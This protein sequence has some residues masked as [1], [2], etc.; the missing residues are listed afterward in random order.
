MVVK[1]PYL[2]NSGYTNN[3]HHAH[4]S[5]GEGPG[6]QRPSSDFAK[7]LSASLNYRQN[8]RLKQGAVPTIVDTSCVDKKTG[9]VIRL[10][11][12]REVNVVTQTDGD[13]RKTRR[14]SLNK[15]G[16]ISQQQQQQ[17]EQQ[18]HQWRNFFGPEQHRPT[19]PSTLEGTSEWLSEVVSEMSFPN[20]LKFSQTVQNL[21]NPHSQRTRSMNS[22][23]TPQQQQQQRQGLLSLQAPKRVF[24]SRLRPTRPLFGTALAERSQ[25]KEPAPERQ[26]NTSQQQD[27]PKEQMGIQGAQ[28]TAS[29]KPVD[30]SQKGPKGS[31][32]DRSRP[33]SRQTSIVSALKK[34]DHKR[35]ATP[36]KRSRSREGNDSEWEREGKM[37]RSDN[38]RD[39]SPPQTDWATTGDG[40]GETDDTLK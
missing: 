10:S 2:S 17:Q 6:F 20:R 15:K 12:P 22:V 35:S 29:A 13:A 16:W 30:S 24:G 38:Q 25:S 21:F 11:Q 37:T 19:L 18:Q 31:K 14:D 26:Q 5:I 32:D 8:K 7:E 36:N 28:S 4:R 9:F 34:Q 23:Q 3:D 39:G 1:Q 40:E 33:L 27:S